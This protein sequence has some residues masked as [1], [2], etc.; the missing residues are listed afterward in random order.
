MEQVGR[1]PRAC[2]LG[3]SGIWENVDVFLF[4]TLT[5]HIQS[6]SKPGFVLNPTSP[7]LSITTSLA[8]GTTLAQ[9]K[10]AR[11][12][13]AGAGWSWVGTRL[14]NRSV[15]LF[16]PA[17]PNMKFRHINQKIPVGKKTLKVLNF[18]SHQ[19]DTKLTHETSGAF[20]N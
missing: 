4:L 16:P 20:L 2:C 19:R 5:I 14:L 10:T 12:C 6:I 7:T 8:Q 13:T 18:T 11:G 17:H 3:L 9:A 15:V 1:N